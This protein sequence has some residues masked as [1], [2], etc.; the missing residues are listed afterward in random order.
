MRHLFAKR[1]QPE[2]RDA[3]TTKQRLL[4]SCGITGLIGAALEY[5]GPNVFEAYEFPNQRNIY[6][7]LLVWIFAVGPMLV[8]LRKAAIWLPMAVVFFTF[9]AIDLLNHFLPIAWE[10]QDGLWV[11]G[12]ELSFT[13]FYEWVGGNFWGI[14]HPLLIALLSSV[15]QSLF[16]PLSVFLQ[17][18]AV[19]WIKP[20]EQ[21]AVKDVEKAFRGSFVPRSDFKPKRR[22]DY[23]IFLLIAGAY[24]FFFAYLLL[25]LATGARTLPIAQMFFLNPPETIN[26]FMKLILMFSLALVGAYNVGVRR[27]VGLLLIAGHMVS[28]VASLAFYLASP[29]NP[30]YPDNHG[31][32]FSSFVADGLIVLFLLIPVLRKQPSKP[33]LSEAQDVMVRSPLATIQRGLYAALAAIYAV[34]LGLIL[35]ARIAAS[36]QSD[37]GAIFGGPDPLVS[38][39]LTKYGTLAAAFGLMIFR[40]KSRRILEPTIIFGL[41]VTVLGTIIYGFQGSTDIVTRVGQTHTVGWFI[42]L[43]LVVDLLALGLILYIRKMRYHVELGVSALGPAA[44]ECVLALHGA[45]REEDQEPE[46]SRTLVCQRLDEHFVGI[47]G[48]LRGLLTFPFSLIELLYPLLCGFRPAF[49]TMSRSEQRWMLRRY[50]TKPTWERSRAAIPPLA[51]LLYNVGQIAHGLVT[52]SYFSSAAGQK[53]VGYVL[54]DARVRLQG[55]V[56]DDRPP[57]GSLAL[58]WPSGPE[59]PVCKEPP[60]TAAEPSQLAKRI[61]VPEPSEIPTEV[62]YCVIGSGA[63]GAVT[64]CRLSEEL[65]DGSS[66][67]VIER[68]GYF[69]PKQDFTDDE[70]QMVRTLFTEGGLQAARTFD[71]TVLQGECVGGSTVINNA[72]CFRIPEP[73]HQEWGNFGLDTSVLDP[74]F[75]RVGRE[76]Q[77]APC[78]PETINQKVEQLFRKGVEAY[79]ANPNDHI[80]PISPVAPIEANFHNCTGCGLCVFGCR[81]MRK[82]SCLETYIPWS[83]ARGVKIVPRT[84]AVVAE[85]DKETGTRKVESLVVRDRNGEFHRIKIKKA[86]VVAAGAV[87]S[88][89]FLI[90]SKVGGAGAGQ[91]LSC[92]YATSPLVEFEHNIDAFDGNQMTLFSEPASH[93]AMFEVTFNPPGLYSILEALHFGRHR[94]VMDAY[95]RTINFAAIVRSDASGSIIRKRDLIFGRAVDWKASAAD[96]KRLANAFVTCAQIAKGAGGKR[97][98][99]PTLPASVLELDDTLDAR[100]EELSRVIQHPGFINLAT[101]HPMGGNAMAAAGFPDRVVELDYRVRGT[102]NLYVSDASVFPSS[103]RANPQWTVMAMGSHAADKIL[104]N[105]E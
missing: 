42:M 6:I 97:I 14:E 55:R 59:D 47:K 103:L 29:V 63:A 84:S 77:I 36:A 26:S 83:V 61:A 92:N 100:L 76:L 23:W 51:E 9:I 86:L 74:H 71:F 89:R 96:R 12:E 53:Q 102:E 21:V 49:S 79:N 45:Y 5:L 46:R 57:I 50:V 64:A 65:G 28:V 8:G 80:G 95:R 81:R 30:L 93:D 68:G 19:V 10:L 22:F 1:Y 27:E 17:R 39:S 82:L 56:A 11:P 94:D 52:L 16:V 4:L 13:R 105:S 35:V 38:N 90:R 54:P 18:L 62:D 25:V 66:I 32:L 15:I 58:P 88:S 31:F 33:D 24:M 99:L 7:A 91:R 40:S 3:L 73:T 41:S 67:A 2:S 60:H 104:E 75:E 98:Y 20:P 48:R 78:R 43:Q 72:I 37:I 85:F 101:S 70:M 34:T 69:S 87:A 44:T